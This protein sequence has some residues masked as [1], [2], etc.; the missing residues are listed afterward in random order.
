MKANYNLAKRYNPHTKEKLWFAVP[1]SKGVMDAD[2][3]ARM[4]V[5]DTT[6]SKGEYKHVMEVTSEKLMPL[7][8]S[9]ITVTIG[10]L[11][12]LRLSFGSEGVADIEDYDATTM[13][14][15]PKFIFTPSK[16]MK[17]AL[18]GA[19]FELEGVVEDGVK[20]GSKASYYEVKGGAPGG[21]TTEPGGEDSGEDGGL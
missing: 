4:A 11:G 21:G 19:T 9:G 14:K 5:A 12:K 1:A 20:Y 7:L 18:S 13:N 3:T 16:E 10:N 6:L 15:N 2:E 8:L 17:E